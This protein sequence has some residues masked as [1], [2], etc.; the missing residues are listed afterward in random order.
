MSIKLVLRYFKLF[1]GYFYLHSF[2]TYMLNMSSPSGGTRTINNS[3]GYH[4]WKL[5]ATID[6]YGGGIY[7]NVRV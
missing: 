5:T 1:I 7:I 2:N 4:N 6:T 3:G